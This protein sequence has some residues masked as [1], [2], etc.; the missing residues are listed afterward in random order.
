MQRL[1]LFIPVTIFM[2]LTV[3]LGLSLHFKDG[4]ELPSVKIGKPVPE[5][6]LPSLGGSEVITAHQLTG[7]PYLLN[8]WQVQCPGCRAEHHFLAELARQGIEIVGVNFKDETAHA[9]KTLGEL[10][11]P[12]SVNL[13]DRDG[14]LSLDLGAYGTPETYIVNSQ[15]I[16]TYRLVGPLDEQ[17]WKNKMAPVFFNHVN[18]ANQ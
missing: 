2:L 14:K 9:L 7:K 18:I 10:G 13:H 8:I 4:D 11:N 6:S 5:F 17:K 1:K 3:M 12:Y 15:G 16:I